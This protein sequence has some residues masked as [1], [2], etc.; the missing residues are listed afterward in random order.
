MVTD[1]S[2]CLYVSCD[3]GHT[4]DVG[5]KEDRQRVGG[6]SCFGGVDLIRVTVSPT[7]ARR[8]KG[9]TRGRCEVP[10]AGQMEQQIHQR[11]AGQGRSLSP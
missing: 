3:S 10:T 1:Y 9:Y 2:W 11:W 4:G 7:G 8:F 5:T 6:H